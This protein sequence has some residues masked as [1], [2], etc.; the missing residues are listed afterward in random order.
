M[1]H[2]PAGALKVQIKAVP[3]PIGRGPFKGLGAARHH[4]VEQQTRSISVADRLQTKMLRAVHLEHPALM[5]EQQ[6]QGRILAGLRCTVL[7]Q[8]VLSAARKAPKRLATQ[9]QN[10][11]LDW[12]DKVSGRLGTVMPPGSL[13]TG[14][15]LLR[16]AAG[17]LTVTVNTPAL[18]TAVCE[19][20]AV[21]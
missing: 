20:L 21:C 16:V 6:A 2:S 11:R 17:R 10:C 12:A 13:S 18:Y 19:M 7:R 9:V 4:I 5:I 8:R 3:H 15:M 14:K 1:Q